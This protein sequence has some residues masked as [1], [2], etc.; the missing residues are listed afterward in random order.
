MGTLLKNWFVTDRNNVPFSCILLHIALDPPVHEA[1]E[2][3]AEAV[4]EGEAAAANGQA[5]AAALPDLVPATEGN[6]V[7]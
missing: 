7:L 1:V 5:V 6:D 2:E 4:D 3:A